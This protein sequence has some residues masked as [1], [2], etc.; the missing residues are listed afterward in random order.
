MQQSAS[1]GVGHAEQPVKGLPGSDHLIDTTP[2]E[3]KDMTDTSDVAQGELIAGLRTRE[4]PFVYFDFVLTH[5]AMSGAI[6]IELAARMASPIQGG[7]V[8]MEAVA[9]A[10]LRCTPAA[11]IFLRDA[12]DAS[13]KMLEQPHQRPAAS[14]GKLN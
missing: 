11:A 2:R 12:L 8:K 5:G 3:K 14:V 4:A 13:V 1:P 10:H 7:G 9:T 6:Q